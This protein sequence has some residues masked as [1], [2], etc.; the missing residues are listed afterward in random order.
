MEL[1]GVA[2]SY[3]YWNSTSYSKVDVGYIYV[4]AD[5]GATWTQRDCGSGGSGAPS[6]GGT[7]GTGG[8]GLAAQYWTSV[9]SSADGTKL[10]AVVKPDPVTGGIGY[11]YTSMDSGATW[12]QTGPQQ[13]WQSVASSADGTKLVAVASLYWDAISQY[14]SGLGHI[15][16]S[17][18]S[19]A[20]W[21]QT[22][23]QQIWNSVASSSDGTK[24]VAVTNPESSMLTTGHIYTSVDS[25]ATWTQTGAPGNGWT[26]VASSSDGTKL[27]AVGF[28]YTSNTGQ[29]DLTN[30]NGYVYISMD[31]GA[32]WTQSGP[33]QAW[34]SVASS[35]DGT[36]LV[37]V[38][39]D[40]GPDGIGGFGY[41]YT[42][43]DSGATWTQT[44]AK[45]YWQS[46]ASSSDGT[47]L[48]AVAAY[49]N[50]YTSADSGATWTQTGSP[51]DWQS[52]ASSSDGT[53]LVA[54]VNGGHIY[55]SSDSGATWTQRQ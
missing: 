19:G 22:G 16:T 47:K 46:V 2:G 30:T 21:T 35:A 23:T 25:G 54:V 13:Y 50:I 45:Q 20:T 15:Y 18:D 17:M 24:L 42:S 12:T 1:R 9:A 37:A 6:T 53:K 26:S 28:G 48:V 32:T 51:E 11:I 33:Q 4:S 36:K 8:R 55:T 40:I 34:N 27:V 44:G 5:S 41:I 39:F 3:S 7:A 49:G 52:V 10:V 43:V 38:G 14:Q 31:S 29:G